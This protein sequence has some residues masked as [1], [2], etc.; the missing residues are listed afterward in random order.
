MQAP[1]PHYFVYILGDQS[2]SLRVGIAG[3]LQHH[4]KQVNQGDAKDA[5]VAEKQPKLVYYEHYEREEIAINREQEIK[6][7]GD[8]FTLRLVESM[9]PNWLDLSDTLV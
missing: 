2:R 7:G 1:Q 3:D 9:N 8:D 4:I 6:N 5:A